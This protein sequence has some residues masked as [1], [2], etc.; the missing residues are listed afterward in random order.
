MYNFN[1]LRYKYAW[2]EIP[3]IRPQQ[4]PTNVNTICDQ[5]LMWRPTWRPMWRWDV[6][7]ECFHS[8]SR[9]TWPTLPLLLTSSRTNKGHSCNTG[10]SWDG[11][12][13]Y[14]FQSNS[15]PPNFPT[16]TEQ[17]LT[18]QTLT[19]DSIF[20]FGSKP[21]F[22]TYSLAGVWSV[23]HCMQKWS[24]SPQCPVLA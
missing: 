20:F 3:W 22:V 13:G 5:R 23:V 18:R 9:L 14:Y 21:S 6:Y 7:L 19:R 1:L 2:N 16:D 8:G 15:C 11:G 4:G 17:F 10:P 12:R 24:I